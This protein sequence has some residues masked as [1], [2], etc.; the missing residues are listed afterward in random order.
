MK[1]IIE[2]KD[3]TWIER[4]TNTHIKILVSEEDEIYLL[5]A[6]KLSNIKSLEKEKK[7]KGDID[8]TKFKEGEE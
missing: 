8:W 3:K 2:D 4:K 5:L 7:E 6:D 1:V